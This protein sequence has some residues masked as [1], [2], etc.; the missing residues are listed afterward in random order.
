MVVNEFSFFFKVNKEYY[1]FRIGN[2][3]GTYIKTICDSYKVLN[4]QDAYTVVIGSYEE[5]E[6]IS[7]DSEILHAM[8]KM[9]REEKLKSL[10]NEG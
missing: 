10:E 1:Y 8:K 7:G 5:L 4:N 9:M 6:K 2:G 3:R